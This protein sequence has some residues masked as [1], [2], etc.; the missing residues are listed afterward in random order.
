MIY[1]ITEYVSVWE[2]YCTEHISM[3]HVIAQLVLILAVP[4]FIIS[5]SE[6]M[7]S[8]MISCDSKSS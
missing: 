7:R 3:F 2:H 6:T 5:Q 4:K 1:L 8:V